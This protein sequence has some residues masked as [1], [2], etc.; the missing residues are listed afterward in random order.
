MGTDGGPRSVPFR[1]LDEAVPHPEELSLK[2]SQVSNQHVWTL[3]LDVVRRAVV[4]RRI[5]PL[6]RTSGQKK[7]KT[8]RKSEGG[9]CT[10]ILCVT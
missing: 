8:R 7:K 4:V 3:N 2:L 10:T 6:Q 5:G 9:S 1:A